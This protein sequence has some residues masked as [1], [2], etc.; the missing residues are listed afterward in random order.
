MP[1]ITNFTGI[2]TDA[3]TSDLPAG[4]SRSQQNVDTNRPGMLQPRKGIQPATLGTAVQIDTGYNTFQRMDFCKTR[5]GR[6][7]GVNGID[8]G[9]IWDGYSNATYDLGID[10]PAAGPTVSTATIKAI[11]NV[12]NHTGGQYKITSSGHGYTNGNVVLIG[13]VVGTGAM[14]SDLNGKQHTITRIDDDNYYI[15]DTVKDGTYASGGLSSLDGTGA[16]KGT[17]LCAY[18]YVGKMVPARFSSISDFTEV[19]ALTAQKF[20]WSNIAYS[21]NTRITK[22]EFWRSTADQFKVLYKVGEVANDTSGSTTTF[23]TDTGDDDALADKIGDDV[24]LVMKEDGTKIAR[25]MEVPPDHF[26]HCISFQDR[27]FYFGTVKYNKGTITR[28]GTNQITGS[29]TDWV[30]T[31]VGRYI[32][33]S[34]QYASF[35]ITAI[36]TGTQVMTLDAD[37]SAVSGGAY[38]MYPDPSARRQMLFSYQDEPESVPSTNSITIQSNNRDDDDIAGAMPSGSSLIVLSQRHKYALSFST[39][40]LSDGSLRYVDDRGVFNQSCCTDLK[41]VHP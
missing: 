39:S 27:Y 29:S 7:V 9:F 38:V 14:Q 31:M 30:S 18:R 34:G 33:I 24:M 40:P 2:I 6:V 17:Y 5:M 12:T 41:V 8:R 10:P 36:N 35:K 32:E 22:I 15:D 20:S 3:D 28:T 16:T 37:P 13:N 25:R 11:T 1:R 19:E 21:S 23:T 26:K 4:S